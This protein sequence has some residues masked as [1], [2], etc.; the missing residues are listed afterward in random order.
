MT[1]LQPEM[2]KF[3]SIN[4]LHDELIIPTN[5]V[6]HL[7][8][9]CTSGIDDPIFI[10]KVISV[11]NNQKA[12]ILS[13]TNTGFEK[14]DLYKLQSIFG[15]IVK[16]KRGEIWEDL[17]VVTPIKEGK[18]FAKGNKTQA[19]HTDDG[20]RGIF[21]P[22]IA[23][24]CEKQ[25][26]K[27]GY[28]KLVFAKDIYDYLLTNFPDILK[29]GFEANSSKYIT[30][31]GSFITQNFFRYSNQNIGIAWSPFADEIDGTDKSEM[32]Y[33]IIQW[34]SH[35][36]QYQTT[37]KLKEGEILV[38]DNTAVLHGRTEFPFEEKRRLNRLW[39]NGI[40]D[41]DLEPGVKV[42]IV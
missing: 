31:S 10:S 3:N 27:G 2:V 42:D 28:S 34:Y 7:R 29:A 13:H 6:D 37:F 22:I 41:F 39:F 40:S 14:T 26:T 1:I 23:L 12:V 38:A 9:Q 25:A 32:L 30:H 36:P 35:Q 18:T 17:F 8:V 11:F 21:P 15:C 5:R 19:M 33:R 4:Y 16:Q 24:H 20:F